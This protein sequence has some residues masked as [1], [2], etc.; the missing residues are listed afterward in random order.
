MLLA[1]STTNFNGP[2]SNTLASVYF[3]GNSV[4]ASG[5][6]GAN[7]NCGTQLLT[8]FSQANCGIGGASASVTVGWPLSALVSNARAAL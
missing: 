2:V 7:N 4:V 6:G 3:S 5:N 1:F 8:Q